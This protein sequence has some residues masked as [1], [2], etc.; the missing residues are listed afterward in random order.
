[1]SFLKRLFGRGG[2]AKADWVGLD[3]EAL[4]FEGDHGGTRLWR[5]PEGDAVG[6]YFFDLEPDLPRGHA[7]VTEFIAAYRATLE[8]SAAKLVEADVV[9][10]HDVTM[11]RA[12]A[13]VPQAPHG[14]TFLGSFTLPFRDFS[15]VVKVQCEEYGTTGVREAMLLDRAL[16]RG[17]A[18][19]DGD[20]VSGDFDPDSPCH[21]SEF[22]DH[23]LSRARRHLDRIEA[24]LVISP[25][26]RSCPP[27]GL[28]T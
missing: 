17:E 22:P 4:T 20:G 25:R 1:M 7:G 18:S 15:F 8:L 23:P 10:S 21:D 27:F 6:V 2:S 5:L 13:K 9:T 19:L 14:V 24:S 12:I 26:L 28:P 11:L 16:A 3:G